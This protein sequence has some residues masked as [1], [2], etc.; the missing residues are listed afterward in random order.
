VQWLGDYYRAEDPTVSAA[1]AELERLRGLELDPPLPDLS[2]SV[3]LLRAYLDA[4]P[5]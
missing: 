3:G 4:M 2:R 5:R 1:R